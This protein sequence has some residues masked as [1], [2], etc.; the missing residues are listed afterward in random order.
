MT[1]TKAPDR[2]YLQCGCDEPDC[3]EP[4][5]DVTWC[6]DRVHDHDVEYV[7]ADRPSDDDLWDETLAERDA[8]SDALAEA[9][10]ILGGPEWCAKLPPEEP[11]DSGD[12]TQDVP[13]LCRQLSAQL[14]QAER[15]LAQ[16]RE[17]LRDVEPLMRKVVRIVE[18]WN[19]DVRQP[20]PHPLSRLAI[21]ARAALDAALALSQPGAEAVSPGKPDGPVAGDADACPLCGGDPPIPE[22]RG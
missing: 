21:T 2:I 16:A 8:Y 1:A 15:E 19:L 13:E 20:F 18:D 7:R 10:L 12:L 6:E 14:Q 3:H 11:P 5:D 22:G 17:A 9:S 4:H